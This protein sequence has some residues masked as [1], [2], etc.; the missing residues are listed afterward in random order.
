MVYS[1]LGNYP[2]HQELARPK[3][4]RKPRN[5]TGEV[6]V[7]LPISYSN[8]TKSL[9]RVSHRTEPCIMEH[10][11]ALMSQGRGETELHI[12]FLSSQNEKIVDPIPLISGVLI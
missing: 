11:T 10:Y 1:D 6:V 12:A 2:Q 7:S 4:L 5:S 8:Y 9:A 3:S